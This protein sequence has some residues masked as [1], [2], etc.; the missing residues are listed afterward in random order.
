MDQLG[1]QGCRENIDE[2]VTRIESRAAKVGWFK[3]ASAGAKALA[4]G[5]PLTVRGMVE[6]AIERAEAKETPLRP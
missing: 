2:I 4:L 1:V 5:L 3:K 6:L